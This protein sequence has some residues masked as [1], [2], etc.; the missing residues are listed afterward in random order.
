MKKIILLCVMAVIAIGIQSCSTEE[1]SVQEELLLEKKGLTLIEGDEQEM[2]WVKLNVTYPK[3]S[4]FKEQEKIA[5]AF[6]EHVFPGLLL[7][8]NVLT[9]TTDLNIWHVPLRD[10][11]GFGGI[12]SSDGKP[13]EDGK[14]II[15]EDEEDERPTKWT[16][17]F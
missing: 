9:G 7:S 16:I 12:T 8:V 14:V 2:E 17:H 15:E 10:L 11:V 1:N 13:E 5:L 3:F 4:T 6:R